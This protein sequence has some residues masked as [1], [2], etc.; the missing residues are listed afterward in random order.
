MNVAYFDCFAGASGDMILGALVDVGLALDDLARPLATLPV[1]G[2]HL[3]AHPARR[4]PIAGTKVD[5]V[6]EGNRRQPRRTLDD[7]LA[8]IAQG[9]FP[10]SVRER[11]AAVFRRLAAA[12]GKVHGIPEAEVHFHEVGAVDA[13][14]DVVGAALGLHLL[15]V[16]AVYASP[17]PAGDGLIRTA[18][19]A[20]PVPAPATLELIALAKAPLRPSP[21]GHG[22][23]G[24][25]VTPTAAALL[26]TLAAFRQPEMTLER[27]G[28]GVGTREHPTLPNVLRLWLGQEASIGASREVLL[29]ETNIDDMNPEVYGY[30]LERLLEQGA[31]D[32]WLTPVQMKKNR[33]GAVL[34][35]LCAPDRQA[36]LLE[37][38]LRE[39]STLGVRIHTLRRQ[40]AE[41]EIVRF[42]SSLGEVAVKVKRLGG[43]TVGLSPE[44]EDCRRLALAHKLP[45]REVYRR[46]EAEARAQLG[47]R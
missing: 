6:L 34:S 30:L 21:P 32:V 14:V 12:E 15:G 2:Y 38:V 17:L 16:E 41:R 9:D 3:E 36:V 1:Q 33:P 11:A 45:L 22:G 8:I 5:V 46:V 43:Q 23:V 37:T 35:V 13:I 25:M 26:T 24:E 39:T 19:G 4:G 29:L 20:L 18:H 40:E 7:V 31:Y 10:Q 47:L 28:Y 44:Y 42:T 27:I